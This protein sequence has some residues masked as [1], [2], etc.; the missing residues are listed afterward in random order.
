MKAAYFNCIGGVSGD[1]VLGALVDVGLS[2]DSLCNE[3]SKLGVQ[4]YDIEASPDSRSAISGTRVSVKTS[5]ATQPRRNLR[6]ILSLIDES[7]LSPSVKEKATRIFHRLANA[8]SRVHRVGIDHVHFHEVGAVDAIVDIVGAACVWTCLAL[9][10]SIAL[11][12]LPEA[13]P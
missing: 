7:R 12:Y 8:E 1:M 10:K 6:D 3:L 2:I 4:G 9:S 5:S 11:R 13:G